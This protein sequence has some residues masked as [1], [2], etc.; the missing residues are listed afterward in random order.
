MEDYDENKKSSYFQYWD[1]N[2]LYGW[3]MLHKLPINKDFIKKTIMK[4]VM[5]HIFLKLMFN[6]LTN[7]M[8]NNFSFLPGRMQI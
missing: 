5:N 1:A 4:K 8:H 6:V 2:N 3:A 7:Y